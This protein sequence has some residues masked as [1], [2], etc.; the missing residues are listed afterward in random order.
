MCCSTGVS[1]RTF[2]EFGT[3]YGSAGTNGDVGHK[4]LSHSMGRA[5]AASARTSSAGHAPR[6]TKHCAGRGA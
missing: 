2:C 4:G 1:V 3:T 6:T 5:C